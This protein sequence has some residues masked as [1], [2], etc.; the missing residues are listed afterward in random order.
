MRQLKPITKTK[1]GQ[2]LPKNLGVTKFFF[3]IQPFFKTTH[4]I[5]YF[6]EFVKIADTNCSFYLYHSCTDYSSLW[7]DKEL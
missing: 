2:T 1:N 6:V 5:G 7:L 3:K 4:I